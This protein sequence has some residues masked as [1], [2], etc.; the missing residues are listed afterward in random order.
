[1][2]FLLLL[3]EPMSDFYNMAMD[4]IHGTPTALNKFAD[5]ACLVVNVAS[6]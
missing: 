3:G 4:D 1:M 5:T 2:K 6:R